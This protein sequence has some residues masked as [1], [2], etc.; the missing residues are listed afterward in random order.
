MIKGDHQTPFLAVVCLMWLIHYNKCIIGLS[1]DS[2]RAEGSI[3]IKLGCKTCSRT[4]ASSLR[5]I[6]KNLHF[7]RS[8]CQ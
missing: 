2:H 3:Y 1:L 4:P 7:I 8:V 5:G 6:Q